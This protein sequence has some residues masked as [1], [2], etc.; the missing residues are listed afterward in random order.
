MITEKITFEQV[1]KCRVPQISMCITKCLLV[2]PADV[3]N[4]YLDCRFKLSHCNHINGRQPF[5]S[6]VITRESYEA[7]GWVFCDGGTCVT[8][9][10]Q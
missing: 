4:A 7:E 6:L 3:H 1:L 5:R 2:H 10:K 9:E 8:T